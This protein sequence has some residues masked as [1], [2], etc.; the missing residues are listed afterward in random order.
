MIDTAFQVNCF[1]DMSDFRAGRY[2]GNHVVQAIDFTGGKYK[3]D[4]R[5]LR[6]LGAEVRKPTTPASRSGTR[7]MKVQ[8]T[9]VG[10]Y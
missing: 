4:G 10:V 1:I 9:S 2:L 6:Q 3:G 7:G 5:P 8:L